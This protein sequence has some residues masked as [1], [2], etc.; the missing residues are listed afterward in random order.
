MANALNGK[1]FFIPEPV[2]KKQDYPIKQKTNESKNMNK[3]VIKINENTLRQ[4][5][6]ESV[7]RVLNEYN[8]NVEDWWRHNGSYDREQASRIP[9]GN[10][11][12]YLQRTDDWWESLSDEEKM[13]I[14]NN[15]FEEY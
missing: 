15:Y 7:K 14:Y 1:E 6:A 11:E 9:Y 5:V 10:D 2:A 4:I 3:N 12:D 8:Q 13:K